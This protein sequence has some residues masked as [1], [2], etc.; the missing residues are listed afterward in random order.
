MGAPRP[1]PR[2][3]LGRGAP[4]GAA[5]R[6]L[7]S[8]PRGRLGPESVGEGPSRSQRAR[9][10]QDPRARPAPDPSRA[11]DP[12]PPH[13]PRPLGPR[14]RL[15]RGARGLLWQPRET[16]GARG[17]LRAPP[18]PGLRGSP[19]PFPEQAPGPESPLISYSPG[20]AA[21]LSRTPPPPAPACFML[22]GFRNPE[23]AGAA[24][25]LQSP[26]KLCAWATPPPSASQATFHLGPPP[27]QPGKDSGWGVGE[28]KPTAQ[29]NPGGEGSLRGRPGTLLLSRA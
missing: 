13:L 17:R 18:R 15:G 29:M 4:G 23:A 11:G 24:P 1:R 2:L 28:S 14:R 20:R 10:A 12:A 7:P 26:G 9:A 19:P 6:S 5:G 8:A 22:K 3:Q 16:A 25:R 27:S 21:R